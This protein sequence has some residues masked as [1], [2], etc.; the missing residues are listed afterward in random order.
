MSAAV[1]VDEFTDAALGLSRALVGIALRTLAAESSDLTLVQFRALATLSD[2]GSQR[3]ADLAHLL[4]VNSS[5]ATRMSSRLRRKGLLTRTADDDDRRATRLTIT[6]AGEAVV[7][8]VTK[9]RQAEISRIADRIPAERRA[10]MV[11]AM[12]LFIVAAGNGPEQD[13][14]PGWSR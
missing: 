12:H 5:T 1:V 2:H 6:P 14:T 13:W 8:A 11:E 10:A 3:V 7:R 9:R 4:G